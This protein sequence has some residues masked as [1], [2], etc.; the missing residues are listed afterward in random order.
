MSR[1]WYHYLQ[2]KKLRH[3]ELNNPPKITHLVGN[4]D[5]IQPDCL[6]LKPM[7]GKWALEFY[8]KNELSGDTNLHLESLVKNF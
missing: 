4:G 5:Q 2:R 3:R 6:F 1:W 8:Q 7:L